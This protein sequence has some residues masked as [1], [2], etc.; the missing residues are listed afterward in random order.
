MKTFWILK[1]IKFIFFVA[2]AVLALSYLVM[3]LWNWLMPLLFHV[4]A[5]TF[6]QALGILALSKIIFGFGRWG[7]S[8]WSHQKQFYLREKMEEKLKHMTPEERDRFR[9]E[10]KERCG[11]WKSYQ[12][13]TGDK[14]TSAEKE[15]QSGE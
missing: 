7:G 1:G 10:W 5:I 14:G 15:K 9:E 12:W 2:I 6:W 3:A 11:G 4:S 13:P 8:Q